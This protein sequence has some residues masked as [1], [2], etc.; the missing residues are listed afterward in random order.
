MRNP[1]I[2][3]YWDNIKTESMYDKNLVG[4]ET[5]AILKYLGERD[6]VIDV[7]CGEGEGTVRYFNKVRELVALDFSETRLRKLHSR[8][9]GINT[10]LM[11]MRDISRESIGRRFNTAI[12]QRALI[13]LESFSD[14]KKTIQGIYSIL[15]DDGKYIMLE[16][17]NDGSGEINKIRV[18]FGLPKIDVRWYN[19]FFD[20]KK[21]LRF[22]SPYFELIGSRDFSLYF[23]V[24]RVLNA[25]L[26]YPKIPRWDSAINDLAKEMEIKYGNQFIRGVSRLELLV[27]RKK[28]YA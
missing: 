16:G 23:F 2:K 22:I 8:N 9:S 12:T 7:G 25:I 4:I 1:K 14:Q 13:N 20:R 3:K 17:F 27:F 28:R 19:H 21:I 11:D 5:E 18:D 15:E 10:I 6:S 26:K 24:T